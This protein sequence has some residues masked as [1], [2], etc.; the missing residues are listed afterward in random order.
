MNLREDTVS[1]VSIGICLIKT[2]QSGQPISGG[3]FTLTD[4]NGDDVSQSSYTAGKNGLITTAHLQDGNYTLTETKAPQGYKKLISDITFTVSGGKAVSVSDTDNCTLTQNGDI[5][6]IRIKNR[7][8]Q[9]QFVKMDEELEETVQ[10]AKFA[11]Y[12]ELRTSSGVMKDYRPMEGYEELESDANGVIP[13]LDFTLP[14][15]T[16]YLEEKAAPSGYLSLGDVKF[17]V[18]EDASVTIN[19]GPVVMDVNEGSTVT[20]YKIKVKNRE[21]NGIQIL[22][23]NSTTDM[24]IPNVG[25]EL[26]RSADFNA[27]TNTPLSGRTYVTAGVTN[28]NGLLNIGKLSNGTYYLVETDPPVGYVEPSGPI[29]I[30]VGTSSVTAT[31]CQVAKTGN[32]YEIRVENTPLEIIVPLPTGV[33]HIRYFAAA[34]IAIII[35]MWNIRRKKLKKILK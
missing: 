30:D 17:T 24:K 33:G 4:E 8:S 32:T 2:D 23:V 28:A 19:D 21:Y 27:V 9:L 34:F 3:T 7:E 13:K 11:L 20:Q 16:Y 12:K 14:A 26:Y 22:K 6:E 35:L 31:N 25:F 15:G 1:N 10:G 18:E 5:S 29:R